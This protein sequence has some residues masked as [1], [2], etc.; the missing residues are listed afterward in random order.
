[1]RT[2]QKAGI[3]LIAALILVL[4]S[5]VLCA[6]GVPN[7]T[8]TSVSLG[9]HQEHG[10]HD[11]LHHDSRKSQGCVCCESLLCAP[12]AEVARADGRLTSDRIAAFVPVWIATLLLNPAGI[13]ARLPRV[14]ESPPSHTRVRIFL[15][16][17]TLLL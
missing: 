14:S 9:H 5:A 10:C 13:G 8:P 15:V 17:K 6:T 2:N 11:H 7:C 4:H 12:R 3:A 16:Q 1:M